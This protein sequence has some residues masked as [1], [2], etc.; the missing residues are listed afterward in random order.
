MPSSSVPLHE[1][2]ASTADY[3]NHDPRID[4]LSAINIDLPLQVISFSST[5]SADYEH[6]LS[7]TILDHPMPALMKLPTMTSF[8]LRVAL[9]NG[10]IRKGAVFVALT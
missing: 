8:P 9:R 10:E 3:V 1:L 7:L 4:R 2:R 6:A 5:S